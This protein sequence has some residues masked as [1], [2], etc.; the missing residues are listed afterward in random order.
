MGPP[1]PRDEVTAPG[2]PAPAAPTAALAPEVA[3]VAPT[4]P[5]TAS[6]PDRATA[7]DNHDGNTPAPGQ[8]MGP[9]PGVSAEIEAA[10]G[11]LVGTNDHL[12]A[13]SAVGYAAAFREVRAALG[14][15]Y[16]AAPVTECLARIEYLAICHQEATEIVAEHRAGAAMAHEVDTSDAE[17]TLGELAAASQVPAE[18][19]TL[20]LAETATIVLLRANP[21]DDVVAPTAP[22]APVTHGEMAANLLPRRAPWPAESLLKP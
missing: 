9:P 15:G 17:P 11:P 10:K 1:T 19:A 2:K 18:T 4:E 13:I 20:E 3:P 22:A 5:V 16:E 6:T 8:G 7:T 21:A 12:N 14:A